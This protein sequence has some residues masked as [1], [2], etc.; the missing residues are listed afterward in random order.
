MKARSVTITFSDDD[1]A[2]FFLRYVDKA[3]AQ[4][5]TVT[6]LYAGLMCSAL[7][8]ATVESSEGKPPIEFE[9]FTKR[10]DDPKLA[11]LES[12]LDW[13]GIAHR[14]NGE[15]WHAPILEVDKSKLDVA[16]A[17]V[18]EYGIDE[19]PDDH[20][21]FRRAIPPTY[22]DVLMAGKRFLAN[23]ERKGKGKQ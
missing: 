9:L 1:D 17:V 11:W 14:R 15:S 13:L 3:K 12:Q 22:T 6:G 8:R 5:G 10:T 16:N 21:V 2:G 19:L 23:R 18:L 20:P 4:D 7:K